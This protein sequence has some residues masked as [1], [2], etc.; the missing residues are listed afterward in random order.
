M[1]T[2]K[3]LVTEASSAYDEET[4]EHAKEF[5]LDPKHVHK[6]RNSSD[7]HKTIYGW[8]KQGHVDLKTFKKLLDYS[9]MS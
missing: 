4:L 1:K 8:V 5:K 3:A 7:H 9:S 6:L 2:F